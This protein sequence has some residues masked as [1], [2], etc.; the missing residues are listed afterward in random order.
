[1][2]LVEA[3]KINLND[4]VSHYIPGFY[5]KYNHKSRYHSDQLIAQT[6]GISG[7]ITNDDKITKDTNSLEGLVHSI[8]GRNLDA[9]PGKQFE[10]SNMNYDILGLIVQKASHQSYA[11]YLNTH[12]SLHYI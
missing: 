7:D 8:K 9:K 10:Y 12:F 1:M 6:S 11:T 2:Q 5:M 3:H 4:K